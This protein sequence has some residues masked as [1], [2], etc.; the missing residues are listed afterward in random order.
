MTWRWLL[1]Y[2]DAM[3]DLDRMAVEEAGGA[4]MQQ[5]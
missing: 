1:D 3:E 5:G 2:I 4:Q